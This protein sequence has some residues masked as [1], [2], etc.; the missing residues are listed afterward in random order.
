MRYRIPPKP[1][2]SKWEGSQ[3]ILVTLVLTW[4][5]LSCMSSSAWTQRRLLRVSNSQPE[6][7]SVGIRKNEGQIYGIEPVLLDGPEVF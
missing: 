5:N 3:N 7:I 1:L 2:E 6:I 4:R